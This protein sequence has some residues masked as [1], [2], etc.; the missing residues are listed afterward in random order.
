MK[1]DIKVI[2]YMLLFFAFEA[3]T[4]KMS[5]E[6][7]DSIVW[8]DSGP[9]HTYPDIFES[10]TFSFRIQNFLRPHVAY[11]NRIHL[12]T[13]IRWYP[14]SLWYPS[15]VNNNY[16]FEVDLPIGKVGGSLLFERRRREL[17]KGVWGHAPPPQKILKFRCLWMLFSTFSR[18]HLGLKSNQN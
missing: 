17:P 13:C 1:G 14:D 15:A 2:R 9:V 18:Q 12:S 5:R 6:T 8:N 10:A 11:S 16:Y 3:L 7:N 4:R